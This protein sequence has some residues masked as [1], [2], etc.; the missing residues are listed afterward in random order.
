MTSYLEQID[1]LESQIRELKKQRRAL[2]SKIKCTN[3][4][5][6]NRAKQFES[7]DVVVFN[8]LDLCI[9]VV[10]S[11]KLMHNELS[12]DITDNISFHHKHTRL[13][14]D[15]EKTLLGDKQFILI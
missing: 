3:K 2:I 15:F 11:S 12:Y 8:G 10:R 5:D 9:A 13:A 6:F 4:N 1:N 14:T 7:G